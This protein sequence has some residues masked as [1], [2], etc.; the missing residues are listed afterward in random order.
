MRS[1][2]AALLAV[3]LAVTA[4]MAVAQ[5]A[6]ENAVNSDRICI[7]VRAIRNFDAITDQ[8]VYVREGSNKHYLFTMQRG[9]HYLSSALSIAITDTTSRVCNDGFGDIVYRD[10]LSGGRLE[11]CRIENIELF[12]SKEDVEAVAKARTEAAREK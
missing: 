8:Y 1:I 11:S 7:N 3:A 2:K 6:D 4:P 10:R 12:S 9:C 5:D